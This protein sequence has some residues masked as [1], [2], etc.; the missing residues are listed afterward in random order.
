MTVG[1]NK[2]NGTRTGNRIPFSVETKWKMNPTPSV[3]QIRVPSFDLRCLPGRGIDFLKV[4][5]FCY[6][7]GF[8]KAVYVP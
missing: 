7:A 8:T 3:W 6:T 2:V 1:K 4:K 5:F